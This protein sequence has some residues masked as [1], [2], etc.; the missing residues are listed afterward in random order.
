MSPNTPECVISCSSAKIRACQGPHSTTFTAT[1]Y[2]NKEQVLETAAFESSLQM[3]KYRI[4]VSQGSR[5][6]FMWYWSDEKTEYFLRVMILQ[7]WEND[8]IRLSKQSNKSRL[9][10]AKLSVYAPLLRSISAVTC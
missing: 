6:L 8:D 3:Y 9:H 1:S 7:V 10:I 5:D 2:A 4:G